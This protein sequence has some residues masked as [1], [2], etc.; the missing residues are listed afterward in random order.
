MILHFIERNLNRLNSKMVHFALT[1]IILFYFEW[2]FK[3]F[4]VE[5]FAH[6]GFSC[7]FS[8][9][10]YVIGKLVYV[11][12]SYLVFFNSNKGLVYVVSFFVFLFWFIP[13]VILYQFTYNSWFVLVV[14]VLLFVGLKNVHLINWHFKPIKIT[15]NKP[16]VLWV[17]VGLLIVLFIPFIIE[18]PIHFKKSLLTFGP[19]LYEIRTEVALLGNTFTSYF[20]SPLSLVFCPFLMLYGIDKKKYV[21]SFIALA[22]MFTLYLM[23]PYKSIF[24][25]IPVILFFALL[26]KQLINKISILFVVLFIGLGVARIHTLTHNDR[27]EFVLE[28]LLIRRTFFVPAALTYEYVNIFKGKPVYLAHSILKNKV[29][30]PYDL[31]PPEYVAKKYYGRDGISANTGIIGDGFMNFGPIGSLLYALFFIVLIS[32]LAYLNI[33]PIYFGLIF[34]MLHQLQN[35]SLNTYLLTHGAWLLIILLI[36]ITPK[37]M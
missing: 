10:K 22:V 24:F 12:A 11:V 28:S 27:E 17:L 18:F 14:F 33:K 15:L 8:L 20:I 31:E 5:H 26:N 7:D 35:V 37:K 29:D 16:S 34:L 4:V 36:F 6:N 32:F 30:Y 1:S 9:A 25:A 2:N 23:I 21:V 13:S 19:E 3:N